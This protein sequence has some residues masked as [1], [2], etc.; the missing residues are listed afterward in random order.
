M[1][2]YL[3]VN[4]LPVG[5]K[6]TDNVGLTNTEARLWIIVAAGKQ[7]MIYIVCVRACVRVSR[8]VGV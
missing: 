1:R 5:Y 6:K 2:S 7:Q 4:T 3:A 8:H